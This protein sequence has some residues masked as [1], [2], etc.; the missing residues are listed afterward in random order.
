MPEG[1]FLS[2]QGSDFTTSQVPRQ[3]SQQQCARGR[4]GPDV[5]KHAREG[6][7]LQCSYGAIHGGFDGGIRAPASLHFHH[8]RGHKTGRLLECL[9]IC[10]IVFLMRRRAMVF[11]EGECKMINQMNE[12]RAALL[13]V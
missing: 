7:F 10:V 8:R 12:G 6:Y 5:H 2:N 3:S 9:I 4:H 11:R 13:T 1:N